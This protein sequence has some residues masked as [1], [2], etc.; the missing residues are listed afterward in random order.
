[1]NVLA[2][3][4]IYFGIAVVCFF[5][6][7]KAKNAKKKVPWWIVPTLAFVGG[8]CL[9]ASAIG[10]WMAGMISGIGASIII[11]VAI[12][13]LLI[14]TYFDLRD[15]EA[16]AFAITSLILLPTL[17]IAGTG[18]LADLG[19]SLS[20]GAAESGAATIGQLIGG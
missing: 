13:I 12:V 1:M 15:K 9:A 19:N 18:P 11:G 8:S 6:M 14:G 4:S 3:N 7:K 17:F 5:S 10:S 20:G 16:N 2:L